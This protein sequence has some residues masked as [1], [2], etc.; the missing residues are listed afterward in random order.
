LQDLEDD[1]F[2]ALFEQPSEM[3][4]E[5][6]LCHHLDHTGSPDCVGANVDETQFKV[7]IGFVGGGIQLSHQ[8]MELLKVEFLAL[9]DLDFR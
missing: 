5:V 3:L 9:V 7:D 8:P 1:K 6:R 4:H 2:V